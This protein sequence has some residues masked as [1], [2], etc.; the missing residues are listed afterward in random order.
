LVPPGDDEHDCG[1]KTYAKA[2]DAKLAEQNAKLDEIRAQLAALQRRLLGKSSER[3][4]GQKLPP[5]LPPK[6]TAAETAKKRADALELRGA[7]LE[8][9]VVAVP[10]PA[11]KCTCPECGNTELRRVGAGKP[12]TVF[13]YVQPHFRKR[14]Y[15]RET[16]SCRCGHIVTAPAPDRVGE[17][18]RYA[19]SF[20]AHLVVSKVTVRRWTPGAARGSARVFA[21]GGRTSLAG[22]LEAPRRGGRARSDDR[23]DRGTPRREAEDALMV[24]VDART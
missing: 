19:A 14:I 22:I 6:T 1:W 15:R 13:E 2:Q 23:A 16:L 5:P 7:K 12:S 10:V 9:E 8:T 3:R 24:A 4:K 21:R 11:D 17:K 18:T 20:I